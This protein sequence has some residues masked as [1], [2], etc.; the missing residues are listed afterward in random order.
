M[1]RDTEAA[2]GLVPPYPLTVVVPVFDAADTIDE[3]TARLVTTLEPR[4]PDLQILLVDDRSRDGSWKA[5]T[6]LAE[7]HRSV[8]GVRLEV[9]AGQTA[10]WCAGFERATGDV[11]VTID[12]DLD[13]FPEDIPLLLAA[14]EGGADVAN[15]R[16]QERHW[17]RG[18][19]SKTFNGH[20]RR[21]G[22]PYHDIGCGM[23]ALRAPLA[24]RLL[25]HG[26]LRRGYRIKVL[27][28]QLS[29]DLVEVPIR[30][31]AP[32][33]SSYRMTDLLAGGLEA[34]L[35]ARHSLF[36]GVG[37]AGAALAALA[38]VVAVAG[39]VAALATGS[40]AGW[41]V[42]A[43]GAVAAITATTLAVVGLTANLLLRAAAQQSAPFYRVAESTDAT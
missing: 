25:E 36:G 42:A 16:R 7:Q 17:K 10:A 22:L 26:E 27:I 3:L 21:R 35:A 29:T 40:A 41:W 5:I 18:L 19:L 1:V 33:P 15:G 34:E 14:I 37:I 23:V 20:L 30:T 2:T 43:G 32:S 8:T 6:A 38:A 28:A 31:G 4:H 13:T 12:A 9:N 39:L 24:R 11:V